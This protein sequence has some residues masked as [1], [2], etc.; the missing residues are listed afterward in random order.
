[1]TGLP[2][3][4]FLAGPVPLTPPARQAVTMR[5]LQRFSP[6][7][8][9]HGVVLELDDSGSVT[10]SLHSSDMS[11]ISEVSQHGDSL[12][13]GSPFAEFLGRVQAPPRRLR[14]RTKSSDGSMSMSVGG[15]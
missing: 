1:M 2:A 11:C 10:G 14:V 15:I 7:R 4:V 3:S 9:D 13:V 5:S 6:D 12:Y 8:T